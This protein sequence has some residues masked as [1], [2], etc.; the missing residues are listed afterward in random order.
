MTPAGLAEPRPHRSR[1]FIVA[2]VLVA[3]AWSVIGFVVLSPDT[4]YSG[5]LGVNYVQTRSLIKHQYRSMSLVYPGAVIDPSGRFFPFRPPFILATAV[6]VQGI[7]PPIIALSQAPLVQIA[8]LSGLVAL[9]VFSG[10]VVLWMAGRIG[11]VRSEWMLPVVLGL[12]TCL[13]FYAIEPWEHAPAAALDIAAMALAFDRRPGRAL[14]AG[15]LLGM[16]TSLRNESILLAPG[17]LLAVWSARGRVSSLLV[18]LAGLGSVLV[19]VGALDALVYHRLPGAHALH[20]VSF[21]RGAL[22]ATGGMTQ[23]VPT[24]QRMSLSERYDIVVHYWLISN[25]SNT[26]V[27][28]FLVA[29]AVAAALLRWAH[30][31]LGI[32][33]IALVVLGWSVYGFW[34]LVPEPRWVAGLFRLSP[35]LVFAL[36]PA[37]GLS[38]DAQRTRRICIAT[39]LIV[40]V[41]AIITADT[42]GGKSLGPRHLLAIVPLL[43]IAAW[44]GIMAYYDTGRDSPVHRL[45]AWSGVGLVTVSVALQ[46]ACMV[47][48]YARQNRG[49]HKAFQAI[50]RSQEQVLVADDL[51]A[52]Q[53][54]MPLYFKKVIVL[55]DSPREGRDLGALLEGAHVPAV[56]LISRGRQRESISLTPYQLLGS[57]SYGRLTVQHWRR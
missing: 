24:L 2:C 28:L 17:L 12:G 36:F 9:S 53:L 29:S 51:V 49:D 40:L 19:G 8:G 25:V 10:V 56:L 4:L 54:A 32:L 57:E 43:T 37:P 34:Q 52:A 47:P 45:L 55:A 16:G 46:L 42:A 31:A 33:L 14:L 6:D 23:E 26:V 5:D 27:L 13:W 18:A 22:K 15:L 44:Q 11:N 35:F 20:A 48:P 30:S 41:S 7:Y 3:A 50:R 1:G 38:P 39:S 21:L